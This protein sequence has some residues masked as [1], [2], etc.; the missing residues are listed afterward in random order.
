MG[1]K[2]SRRPVPFFSVLQYQAWPLGT[3]KKLISDFLPAVLTD[4]QGDKWTAKKHIVSRKKEEKRGE[5]ITAVGRVNL[6][7]G[8][9]MLVDPLKVDVADGHL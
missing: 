2:L 8:F 5:K 7:L 4:G 9:L 3:L 1:K 6:P